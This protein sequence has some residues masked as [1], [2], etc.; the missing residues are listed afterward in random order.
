MSMPTVTR[1][2]AF[3]I[4]LRAPLSRAAVSLVHAGQS[5]RIHAR[6]LH[7]DSCTRCSCARITSAHSFFEPSPCAITIAIVTTTKAPHGNG[8]D[9]RDS[10]IALAEIP[11]CRNVKRGDAEGSSSDRLTFRDGKDALLLHIA[12]YC[13]YSVLYSYST[14]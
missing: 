8:L 14:D 6:G 3:A 11:E 7:T 1:A 13:S 12:L 4:E 9:P 10:D 2:S 5:I